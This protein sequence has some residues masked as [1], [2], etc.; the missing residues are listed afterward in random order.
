MLLKNVSNHLERT[1]AEM[2]QKDEQQ[3]IAVFKEEKAFVEKHQLF[4]QDKMNLLSTEIEP[5]NRFQGAYIERCNKETDELIAEEST[6]FLEKPI[7]YFKS[8][9]EDFMYLESDWFEMIGVDAVSFEVDSVFGTFDVMLGL[10]LPK[11]AEASIK[12]YLTT[13]LNQGDASFNLMFNSN[14]GLWDFNFSLNSL[15]EYNEDWTINEAYCAIYRFLFQLVE[16]IE[17]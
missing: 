15:P 2:K 8:Q 6:V 17:A 4:P 13:H 5:L 11:K 12:T 10:R 14:D 16:E 1:F 9:I 3:K 7:H